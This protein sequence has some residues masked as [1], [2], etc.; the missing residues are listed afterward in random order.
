MAEN[1]VKLGSAEWMTAT[2]DKL[3]DFGMDL[4]AHKMD[5]DTSGGSGTK[6]GTSVSTSMLE[7]K[8]PWILGG[9]AVVGIGIML[10]K[11]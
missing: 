9:L 6:P 1:T 10:W 11:R 5:V 3:L 4:L 7:G 8:L 2:A